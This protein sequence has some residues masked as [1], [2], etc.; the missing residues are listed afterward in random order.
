MSQITATK[1][2]KKQHVPNEA[3][4]AELTQEVDALEQRYVT[5]CEN[6]GLNATMSPD[7]QYLLT[8]Q[9]QRV[10][11]RLEHQIRVAKDQLKAEQTDGVLGWQ[12]IEKK[13]KK[14]KGESSFDLLVAE[15][16]QAAEEIELGDEDEPELSLGATDMESS[17]VTELKVA[18]TP[19]IRTKPVPSNLRKATS[20]VDPLA[21]ELIQL[22]KDKKAGENL[23]MFN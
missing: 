7:S 17:K 20:S 9:Q 12:P 22:N 15:I 16:K 4:I 5:Y 13:V 10:I 1:A 2:K 14:V 18:R 11:D 6:N 21:Q 3:R 19:R 8:P 23:S